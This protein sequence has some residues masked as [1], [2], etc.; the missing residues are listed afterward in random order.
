M[1]NAL[2][3]IR[4]E[5]RALA[6]VLSGLKEFTE[7]IHKGRYQPDFE[8]LYAMIAY[9]TELPDRVHHPKE[10]DYL[11][12]A[13]RK[14]SPESASLLDAL[15][16][17]HREGPDR[18]LMLQNALKRY[19]M[20][21]AGEFPAFRRKVHAYVDDQWQHM[22]TEETKVF[23]LA[24]GVLTAD[25]WATIDAAFAA[26]DNPWEGSSGI[27]KALFTRIVTLAPAPIGVGAAGVPHA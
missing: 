20:G 23:P 18:T 3:I 21:G 26:N 14:R 11:F 25:D 4:D 1:Q 7:G 16:K 5:H 8:L 6:A 9:I 13:L 17:E 19:R 27:Y 10:E 22:T 15:Q 24:R 2:D 12:I